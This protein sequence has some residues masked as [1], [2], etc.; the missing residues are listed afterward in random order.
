MPKSKQSSSKE[1]DK[2]DNNEK[3]EKDHYIY[4]KVS[5]TTRTTIDTL[6]EQGKTISYIIKSAIDIYEIYNSIPD[7]IKKF[8]E[9]YGIQFGGRRKVVIEALRQL[10]TKY[11]RPKASDDDLWD[12]AREELN[13]MIV[14]KKFFGQLLEQSKNNFEQLK[15]SNLAIDPLLWYLGKPIKEL[16]L[17]DFLNA[18]KK[19][20]V[21]FN[22]FNL[23]DV[24]KETEDY[25]YIIFNHR[26]N[27]QYSNFWLKF[28]KELFTSGELPF[29]Y[30]VEGEAYEETFSLTIKKQ[31]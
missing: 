28:F 14:G 3:K 25:F 6:K 22:F 5:D 27:K 12:R 4:A 9:D 24:K 17:E 30:N 1:E 13:V 20:W 19:I 2:T 18:I 29:K 23:I 11:L 8:V 7:E 26:Q 16:S 10:M 31:Y 15:V 21:V